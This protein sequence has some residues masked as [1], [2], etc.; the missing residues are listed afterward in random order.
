[1]AGS[2]SVYLSGGGG[3]DFEAFVR[4]RSPAL[5]RAAYLLTGDRHLAEDLLQDTLIR[6]AEPVRPF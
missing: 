3:E 1:V 5:A 2:G 4:A 6:A